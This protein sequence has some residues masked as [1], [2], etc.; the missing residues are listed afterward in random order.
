VPVLVVRWT[1][2]VAFDT[3]MT[4]GLQGTTITC[5]SAD[6]TEATALFEGAGPTILIVHGGMDDGSSW[7]RV[8]GR[9]SD[10][11]TVVRVV[12]RQYRVDLPPLTPYSMDAEVA[13]VLAIAGSLTEPMIIVGHSSGGVV[14]LETLAAAPGKFAGAVLYEPPVATGPP[15]ENDDS[16][17]RVK[18]ALNAGQPGKAMQ[19]FVR[20]VVGMPASSA[21][22]L[23]ALVATVGRLR[24]LAPRQVGDLEGLGPRLDLYASIQTPVL[25][26][27][28]DRSPAHLG[29]K[30]DV[31]AATLP[32]AEKTV[33]PGRDHGANNKSPA[34]VADVI[35]GFAAKVLR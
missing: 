4:M 26:L 19:I 10:R 34:E 12:R 9:L 22:A 16:S 2:A 14:A 15:D 11:F 1:E 7:Q 32:Q 25:L 18:E 5:K 23:R 6:G 3:H 28:G 20:D 30:L 8:A 35:A 33:M 13:T 21:L 31:L 17:D 27:G 29:E 24:A